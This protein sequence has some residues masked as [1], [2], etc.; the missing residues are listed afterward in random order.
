[1]KE[2]IAA[3]AK[4]GDGYIIALAS[5]FSTAASS[6]KGTMK[7]IRWE[8][9]PKGMVKLN[10]GASFIEESKSGAME[11]VLHDDQGQFIVAANQVLLQVL[12]VESAE[13]LALRHGLDLALQMGCNRVLPSS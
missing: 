6:R 8:K 5:N 9:P 1:L 4:N 3:T 10:V 13:A 2:Q 11:V 7:K 12:D